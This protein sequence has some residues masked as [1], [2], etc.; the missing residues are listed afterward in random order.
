MQKPALLVSMPYL[1]G[2]H[3]GDTVR[4]LCMQ[5]EGP[6]AGRLIQLAAVSKNDYFHAKV[7][8]SYPYCNFYNDI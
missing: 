7:L 4:C 3:T 2:F 1:A 6:I 5:I 8:Q